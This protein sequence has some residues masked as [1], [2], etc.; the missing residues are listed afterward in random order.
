MP[1]N[2]TQGG[3]SWRGC[4]PDLEYFDSLP[5]TARQAL[6]NAVFDWAS[7]WVL[8]QWRRG[9]PGYATGAEIA[10]SIAAADARQIAKDRKRVWSAP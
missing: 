5:P 8:S 3:S 2:A 7:G 6:A 1:S 4:R 9:R 10:R